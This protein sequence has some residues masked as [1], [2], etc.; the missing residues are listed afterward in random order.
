MKVLIAD[1]DH[2]TANCMAEYVRISGHESVATVTTG[3]L[4]VLHACD[5]TKPDLVLLD[6]MMP[7]VNGLTVCHALANRSVCPKIVFLS[8]KLEPDHPFVANAHADAFLAKPISLEIFLKVIERVAAE[9]V[10][11]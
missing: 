10:S 7:K 3:G 1:D 5:Q 9:V 2:Q 11:T 6:V 8:G 4:D